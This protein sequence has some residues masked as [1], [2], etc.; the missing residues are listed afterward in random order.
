MALYFLLC[1]PLSILSDLITN[2]CSLHFF[3]HTFFF[4]E[5]IF[6]TNYGDCNKNQQR[7]W[8]TFG[9]LSVRLQFYL[10]GMLWL[11]WPGEIPLEPRSVW[12]DLAQST[13]PGSPLVSLLLSTWKPN[14]TSH[15]CP[16]DCSC[17]TAHDFAMWLILPRAS[18]LLCTAYFPSRL[19]SV[20]EK[21]LTLPTTS[22]ITKYYTL[23]YIT[24]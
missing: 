23:L 2:Q 1:L 17:P 20:L 4:Q 21:P 12:F 19:L 8:I 11:N 15:H 9:N 24:C 18:F 22:P 3:T 6:S 13:Q 5:T 10:R 16:G 14:Q 7:P